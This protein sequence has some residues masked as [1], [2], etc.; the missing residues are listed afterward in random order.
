MD[1]LCIIQARTGSSRLSGKVL[2][3]IEGKTVLEHVVSRAKK[4]SMISDVV[5]A[6]TIEKSD[7]QIVRLCAEQG[8]RVFCGS[9]DDVL[10]RFYQ[11]AKLL[12]PDNVI[13]ITSD[14]PMIDPAIIDMVI[15]EHIDQKAD[16]TS[17]SL[18]ESYPD[19]E[20]VEV[21]KF[22]ALTTAW[23]ESALK[24][25]REHVTPYIKKHNEIFKL[26]SVV[27]ETD[28]SSK[29]WTLDKQKDFDFI[30]IIFKALYNN[31]NYFGM[32]D[33]LA[34][35]LNNPEVE[36]INNSIERNE[37]YNKSLKEDQI[38]QNRDINNG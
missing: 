27:S 7:L 23:H 4:S 2:K 31:N 29:R 28:F 21:F 13:R 33:I 20:D 32:N 26:F 10:D 8:I 3:S 16:Y 1:F 24:S 36:K 19:G 12:K 14:C 11:C 22:S 38:V 30:S 6:T 18:T 15:Q 9:E 37:G 34:F 35:L 5:V 17:N 25:E